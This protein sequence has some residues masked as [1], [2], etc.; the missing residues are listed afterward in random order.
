MEVQ[1]SADGVEC[2]SQAAIDACRKT[3]EDFITDRSLGSISYS[4][5]L[6]A[7]EMFRLFREMV[8]SGGGIRPGAAGGNKAAIG[9]GKMGV[10]GGESG[11]ELERQ[12]KQLKLEIAQRDQEIG[13]LV[14]IVNRNGSKG[15]G[16]GPSYPAPLS[17]STAITSSSSANNATDVVE[18]SSARH[19]VT[20]EPPYHSTGGAGAEKT[21]GSGGATSSTAAPSSRPTPSSS[22]SSVPKGREAAEL[23]MDR[24][25]AFEVFRK[26]VRRNESYEENK[27]LLRNLM[28]E[29]K[30][31]GVEANSA[32]NATAPIKQRIQQ[33]RLERAMTTGESGDDGE[34]GGSSGDGNG[35]GEVTDPL[36][37]ELLQQLEENKRTYTEQCDKLRKVAKRR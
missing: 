18:P 6:R 4:S 2:L 14:E 35:A 30:Q 26:S 25:K 33:L 8:V 15:G 29:A 21:A 27:E 20:T 23:L 9:D 32:R 13:I 24:N 17:S 5:R 19:Q 34:N 10:S 37:L 28:A 7:Q 22:S 36:E 16:A 31:F 11:P 3:V 12:V 1:T